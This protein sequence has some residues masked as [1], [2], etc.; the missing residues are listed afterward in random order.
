MKKLLSGWSLK[1][2]IYMCVCALYIQYVHMHY[3][4]NSFYKLSK[5]TYVTI[6]R[7][8][9]S[10]DHF[11][12]AP[13]FLQVS[14][15]IYSYNLGGKRSQKEHGTSWQVTPKN[16]PY[17]RRKLQSTGFPI[18]IT[19]RGVKFAWE[20]QLRGLKVCDLFKACKS[21]LSRQILLEVVE[22]VSPNKTPLF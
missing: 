21:W 17:L 22:T 13:R 7:P 16:C 18:V 15:A 4:C 19:R 8:S 10:A 1:I 12:S 2:Y 6:V 9:A 5:H 14:L 11:T 3:D 20:V